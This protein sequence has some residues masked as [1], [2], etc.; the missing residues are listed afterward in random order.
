MNDKANIH[1]FTQEQKEIITYK[2]SRLV[3]IAFAGTGKTFTLIQYAKNN[4]YQRILYLAYNAA[5]KNEAVQKFPKNVSCKTIHQLA[6]AYIGHKYSKKLGTLK[7]QDI[8]DAIKLNDNEDINWKNLKL[9]LD[10]ITNYINSPLREITIEHYPFKDNKFDLT[11]ITSKQEDDIDD[12]LSSARLLWDKMI[13]LN[14]PTPITHD[15]YLKLYQ[16][17]NP[18]LSEDFDTILFDEAQDANKVI[19]EIVLRQN[20]RIILVGDEHQ[21]IYRF[22]GAENALK[23]PLM[24]HERK[25]YL[26]NSFRF[27]GKVALVANVLLEL[28]GETKPVIG[29]SYSDIVIS[30]IPDLTLPKTIIT[31]SNSGAIL[32][33]IE[34]ANRDM[35]IYWIGGIQSYV[36]D[37]IMDVY[38]IFEG[39]ESKIKNKKI[40]GKITS[41][42]ELCELNDSLK[43]PELHRAIN[44]VSEFQNTLPDQIKLIKR[45]TVSNESNADIIITTA[46]KS[47][48]LEWNNVQL[49][50]DFPNIMDPDLDP[51]CRKDEINL[52]YVAVTRAKKVLGINTS[53]QIAINYITKKRIREIEN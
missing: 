36:I 43:D 35:K 11:S 18:N 17:S 38:S 6:Y 30:A 32:A 29:Q 15:T 53:V 2:G 45:C 22:R 50:S 39:K 1:C 40:F 49:Y 27:G 20:C 16:L 37:T 21:Q 7:L 5:I 48:G 52:L 3:V 9:I 25:M 34:E 4:P 12:I 51:D 24:E 26:T 23:H 10:T 47:K 44:L 28:K 19:S 13:N 8:H 14:T 42:S 33:A 31:R 46:H 41:F